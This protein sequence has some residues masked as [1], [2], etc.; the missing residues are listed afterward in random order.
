MLQKKTL[1]YIKKKVKKIKILNKVVF[2]TYTKQLKKDL[3]SLSSLL[4]LPLLLYFTPPPSSKI[5]I[6]IRNKKSSYKKRN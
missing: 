3:P 5:I 1:L 4:S 6:S 2:K